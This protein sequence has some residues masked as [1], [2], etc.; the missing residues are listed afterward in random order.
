MLL[1]NYCN[2]VEEN[3]YDVFINISRNFVFK[4][5]IHHIILEKSR[6]FR[7]DMHLNSKNTA[8][9]FRENKK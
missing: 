1:A 3:L 8:K 2:Q 9:I 6:T 4:I 5:L 7:S